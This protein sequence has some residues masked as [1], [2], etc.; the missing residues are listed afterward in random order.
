M[1]TARRQNHG[2]KVRYAI[3]GIGNI[4]QEAVIP[5]FQHATEN[6]ELVALI[7]STPQ[8]R[9]QVGEK[10]GVE[11]TG[12]YDALEEIIAEAHVDA[13]Y[14]AT[15]NAQHRTLAERALRAGAHVLCEKP[16]AM[17]SDDCQAVI[18]IAEEVGR[19]LMVAYRLHFD[20]ATLRACELAQSGKLGELRMFS[21]VFSHQVREGD[22]R[23]RSETG[24][25][26]LY[27]LGPYPLNMARHVFEAEPVECAAF[28]ARTA[29]STSED[30]DETTTAILRFP[31]GRIAQ[32]VVSQGASAVSNYRIVGTKGDLVVEPAF[33]YA[34]AQTHHLTLDGRSSTRNF[35]KRDQFAPELVHFSNCILEGRPPEPSGYE[36]LADVRIFEALMFSEASG[37]TVRLGSFR[38]P[39]TLSMELEM[40]KPPVGKVKTVHAPSPTQH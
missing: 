25:G 11:R 13:V 38:H 15:P 3:V 14:L 12:D 6:S 39:T 31:G 33:E 35:P 27:D 29:G 36:G 19:F 32:F 37:R 24:G 34:E 16:L 5:A 22:I 4:V 1:A 26:A 21:S 17:N 8:K 20:E 28:T 7:S 9:D 10:T 2:P 23:T 40:H 30:V 18:D